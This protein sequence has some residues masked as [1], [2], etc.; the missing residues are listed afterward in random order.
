ML[1]QNTA[2]A[3]ALIGLGGTLTNAMKDDPEFVPCG[4][5]AGIVMTNV[6]MLGRDIDAADM[7]QRTRQVT[8]LADHVGDHHGAEVAPLGDARELSPAKAD[9]LDSLIEMTTFTLPAVQNG[10]WDKDVNEFFYRSLACLADP[11][12]NVAKAQ[13]AKL[14]EIQAKAR[15]L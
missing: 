2:L 15:E 7:A 4:R 10:I 8:M 13:L 9:L 12:D 6:A 3:G 14:P 5:P 11:T 1:A